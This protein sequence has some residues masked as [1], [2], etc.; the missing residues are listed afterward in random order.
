MTDPIALPLVA[1]LLDMPW[2]DFGSL[3]RFG[4]LDRVVADHVR[5][6]RLD[7]T[8]TKLA[9][10]MVSCPYHF[11]HVGEELFLVLEGQASLRIG[12]ETR[13][14]GPHDVISC[15]PGPEGAHQFTND[16][17]VDFVY[18]AISTED[19]TEICEYPDSGKLL[20]YVR[21]NGKSAFKHV[22]RMRDAVPYLDGE[23]T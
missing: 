20:A 1:N 10:G 4:S 21:R 6:S 22:G 14:V 7:M 23:E 18:L 15:P 13:R 17:D 11:H 19:E 12:A 8:V 5:Q 2:Q 3:G 16:G 9:P